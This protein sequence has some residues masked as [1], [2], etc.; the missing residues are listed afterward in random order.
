MDLA[1]RPQSGLE[2]LKMV[3]IL[4]NEEKNG[5]TMTQQRVGSANE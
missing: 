2:I 5:A 1:D 4:P 3:H